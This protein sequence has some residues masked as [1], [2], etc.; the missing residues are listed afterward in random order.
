M[1]AL[2][3]PQT[4]KLELQTL[5]LASPSSYPPFPLPVPS[6]PPGLVAG[7]QNHLLP[8]FPS[9]S[10]H[11][12]EHDCVLSTM[13][14]GSRVG[15]RGRIWEGVS[16]PQGERLRGCGWACWKDF[17]KRKKVVGDVVVTDGSLETMEGQTSLPWSE[18]GQ[19]GSC[20]LSPSYFSEASSRRKWP[21]A[22]QITGA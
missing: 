20:F 13:R 3:G 4:H 10:C 8:R 15:R 19:K 12:G 21:P 18:R 2:S 5:Q 9:R 1:S 22:S 17:S 11:G 6:E 16:Q 7:P 14:G